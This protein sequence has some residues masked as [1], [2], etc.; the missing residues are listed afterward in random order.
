LRTEYCKLHPEFVIPLSAKFNPA[1]L[2]NKVETKVRANAKPELKLT[3]G[4]TEDQMSVI[5]DADAK[6]VG[7]L[8]GKH[9][10]TIYHARIAYCKANPTFEIPAVAKFVKPA[11]LSNPVQKIDH[12]A[13]IEPAIIAKTKETIRETIVEQV[14]PVANISKKPATQPAAQPTAQQN[15]M[16]EMFTLLTAS[17]MK[18]KK[19]TFTKDGEVSFE[20]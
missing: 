11:E 1:G 18:P 3:A 14:T 19:A 4:L 10:N 20:F 13:E 5:W 16:A 7:E 8:I 15:T 9:Y 2:P 12:K 17:G 6:Q